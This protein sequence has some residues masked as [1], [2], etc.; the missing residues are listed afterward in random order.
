MYRVIKVGDRYLSTNG[1]G[2]VTLCDRQIDATRVYADRLD[3]NTILAIFGPAARSVQIVPRGTF[4]ARRQSH[5]DT[6]GSATN[7]W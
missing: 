3:A 2:D 5:A 6:L 4:D 7:R 1:D